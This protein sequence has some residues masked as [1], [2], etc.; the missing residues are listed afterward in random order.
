METEK[1]EKEV[2]VEPE[3][4]ITIFADDLILASSDICCDDRA[5]YV[6]YT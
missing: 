5:N 6:G 1:K 3:L 4:K 2:F